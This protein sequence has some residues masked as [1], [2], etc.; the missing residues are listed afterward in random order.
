MAI[1]QN[2]KENFPKLKAMQKGKLNNSKIPAIVEE[3]IS[4]QLE[5]PD[6][7]CQEEL[8]EKNLD[9]FRHI[10]DEIGHIK[11]DDDSDLVYYNQRLEMIV[12]GVDSDVVGL[13]ARKI[14]AK[15]K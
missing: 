11:T 4:L 7:Y 14:K 10:V 3:P 2:Y 6:Y 9:F 5:E 12:S 13:E 8:E 1:L 15:K